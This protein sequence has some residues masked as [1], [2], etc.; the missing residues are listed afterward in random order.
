MEA[1]THSFQ[2]NVQQESEGKSTEYEEDS[3]SLKVWCDLIEHIK[4]WEMS[5]NYKLPVDIHT[6]VCT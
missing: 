6:G 3:D 5:I 4:F 1:D 2:H